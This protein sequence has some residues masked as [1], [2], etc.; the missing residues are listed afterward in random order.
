M[1]IILIILHDPCR[2]QPSGKIGAENIK[3]IIP[4]EH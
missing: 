4:E 1:L 3:E 2:I